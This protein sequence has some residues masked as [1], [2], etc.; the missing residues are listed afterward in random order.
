MSFDPLENDVIPLDDEK[1]KLGFLVFDGHRVMHKN[2]DNTKKI[3]K[4]KKETGT[5]ISG[6]GTSMMTDGNLNV[7]N[8][9]VTRVQPQII[10]GN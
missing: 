1:G 10:S 5:T 4:T 9:L 6:T 8:G 2:T 7:K 3:M